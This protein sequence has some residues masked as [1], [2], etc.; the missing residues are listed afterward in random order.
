MRVYR[1]QP[2]TRACG[3]LLGIGFI[4]I[5]SYATLGGGDQ[6]DELTRDRAFW[7]GVT[8]IIG[9]VFAI[10]SSLCV[11]KLDNIWCRPPK[12]WGS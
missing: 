2:L 12:R 8:A 7:F 9:G 3:T 10:L 6:V 1:D 11:K 4:L 5:G